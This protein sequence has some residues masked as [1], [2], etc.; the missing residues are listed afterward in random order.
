M[1][2]EAQFFKSNILS[3]TSKFEVHKCILLQYV[4]MGYLTNGSQIAFKL[5]PIVL[6]RGS[7][8]LSFLGCQPGRWCGLCTSVQMGSP[9]FWFLQRSTG[10]YLVFCFSHKN[11]HINSDFFFKYLDGCGDLGCVSGLFS[12]SADCVTTA[13]LFGVF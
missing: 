4:M 2:Q 12:T 8:T 3:H 9:T 13:V 10:W 5:Q 11:T 1:S 7:E 6:C